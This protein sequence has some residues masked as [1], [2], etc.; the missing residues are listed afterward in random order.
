[1]GKT[2]QRFPELSGTIHETFFR[3]AMNNNEIQ[4][5]EAQEYIKRINGLISRF[6]L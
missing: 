1:V 2:W 6:T 3:K 5:F 4:H